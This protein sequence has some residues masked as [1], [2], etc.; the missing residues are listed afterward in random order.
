MVART[1]EQIVTD[2]EKRMAE[3]EKEAYD[4]IARQKEFD[5]NPINAYPCS[6]CRFFRVSI[7][8][9]KSYCKEPLIMGFVKGGVPIPN[10]GLYPN[11]EQAWVFPKLCGPE[12]ALWQEAKQVQT[13]TATHAIVLSL[14]VIAICLW[15][16]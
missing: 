4:R 1:K 9:N 11:T 8:D 7:K 10:S 15:I 14:L 13:W 6:S 5:E 3:L 16:K 12:K 2:C